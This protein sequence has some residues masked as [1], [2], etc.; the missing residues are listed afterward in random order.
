M[1]DANYPFQRKRIS[2]LTHI[3]VVVNGSREWQ[4]DMKE[5]LFEGNSM[6]VKW[7]SLSWF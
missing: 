3:S 5:T 6:P 7:G 1:F 2:T 4:K